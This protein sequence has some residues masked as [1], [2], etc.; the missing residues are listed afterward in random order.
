MEFEPTLYKMS[1][2]T[3][4][5]STLSFSHLVIKQ[6]KDICIILW[7]GQKK[8]Q[9]RSMAGQNLLRNS[10]HHLPQ[11]SKLCCKVLTIFEIYRKFSQTV[12][13]S[14]L[15]I[16]LTWAVFWDHFLSCPPHLWFQ[17]S[18]SILC[19]L[20]NLGQFQIFTLYFC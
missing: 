1:V 17:K 5:T 15:P 8:M 11:L 4:T 18:K 12:S 16:P 3:E 9:N 6:S 7:T 19:K 13:P 14:D 2:F 10:L 20:C